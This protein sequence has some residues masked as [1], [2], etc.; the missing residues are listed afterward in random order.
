MKV[1]LHFLLLCAS[2]YRIRHHRQDQSLNWSWRTQEMF[3]TMSYILYCGENKKKVG[4]YRRGG[5]DP[6]V[7][8]GCLKV[9]DGDAIYHRDV[10]DGTC[11]YMLT[12]SLTWK[13]N[14]EDDAKTCAE[15][16]TS[17]ECHLNKSFDDSCLVS[18]EC[19]FNLC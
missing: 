1:V 8:V 14:F 4:I 10:K 3:F 7:V 15:A 9:G 18:K 19:G 11:G 12:N 16:V 2:S 13:Q 6:G 5:F 17:S